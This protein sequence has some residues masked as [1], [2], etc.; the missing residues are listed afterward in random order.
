MNC[1]TGS[2]RIGPSLSRPPLQSADVLPRARNHLL[3]ARTKSK[4]LLAS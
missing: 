3:P 2:D 4:P 1:A